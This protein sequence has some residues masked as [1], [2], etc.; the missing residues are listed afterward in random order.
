LQALAGAV[1]VR[2]IMI[3]EEIVAA[4]GI[5]SNT[6]NNKLRI[7]EHHL[8]VQ[9]PKVTLLT[10]ATAAV[11]TTGVSMDEPP[12]SLVGRGS[13]GTWTVD[14]VT[15]RRRSAATCNMVHIFTFLTWLLHLHVTIFTLLLH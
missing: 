11:S 10:K 7:K 8:N 15:G 13:Y 5:L 9:N 6:T 12:D 3:T 2:I 14:S 1:I 4:G